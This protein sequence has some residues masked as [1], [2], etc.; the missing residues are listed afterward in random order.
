MPAAL[1]S[2]VCRLTGLSS[3]SRIW[4]L[5][6]IHGGADGLDIEAV[7]VVVDLVGLDLFDGRVDPFHVLSLVVGHVDPEGLVLREFLAVDPVQLHD[8]RFEIGDEL[9]LADLKGGQF[10]GTPPRA[11]RFVAASSFIFNISPEKYQLVRAFD[12]AA[13][14]CYTGCLMSKANSKG[15]W[16]TI[17]GAAL[18]L[19]FIYLATR[20]V[21]AS[22]CVAGAGTGRLPVPASR[23]GRRSAGAVFAQL[24][25]ALPA[26][27]RAPGANR[28][29]VRRAQHRLHGQHRHAGPSGGVRPRLAL[30]PAKP[31][32]PPA[33]SS[34]PSSSRGSS[35]W[36]P[37]CCC[38][39]W[40][41]WSFLS[42]AG[43]GTAGRSCW[44]WS[45][46]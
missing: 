44:P 3:A 19:V 9:D 16:K 36:S 2:A 14:I 12:F 39:A 15:K 45:P 38:W 22:E 40:P 27:A 30:R 29:P 13:P 28:R 1:D 8:R 41:C 25:L 21:D 46:R 31:A 11:I 17:A 5:D 32:P 20:R 4:V 34:P 37:C 18:S 35:T 43:C 10:H 26:G 6:E 7:A 24:A 33:R 23:A 42:R